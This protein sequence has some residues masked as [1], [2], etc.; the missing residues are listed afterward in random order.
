[1]GGALDDAAL[2]GGGGRGW[3]FVRGPTGAS[4]AAEEPLGGLHDPFAFNLPADREHH[5]LRTVD[6]SIVNEQVLARESIEVLLE[7]EVVS[8][9]WVRP[10][11]IPAQAVE[12][13]REGRIRPRLQL[14]EEQATLSLDLLGR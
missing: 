9:V 1:M 6:P 13:E 3:R 8:P 14:T 4:Q 2:S 7:A 12:A 10:V 11:E 5:L